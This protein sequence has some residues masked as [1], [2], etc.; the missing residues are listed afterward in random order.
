VNWKDS[1]TSPEGAGEVE[2]N[3]TSA[4]SSSADTLVMSKRCFGTKASSSFDSTMTGADWS[5]EITG[6]GKA[7]IYSHVLFSNKNGSSATWTFARVTVKSELAVEGKEHTVSQYMVLKSFTETITRPVASAVDGITL[8]VSTETKVR[9][10]AKAKTSE[11]YKVYA[12]GGELVQR[13]STVLIPGSM[14][15][16]G[17]EDAE[18]DHPLMGQESVEIV[19]AN[20]I[21]SQVQ[22]E[23]IIGN[24]LITS[25]MSLGL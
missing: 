15:G 22:A 3:I 16:E 9:V 6:T 24:P 19:M 20:M 11:G 1:T 4:V 21:R 5:A 23:E 7:G 17:V 2:L 10:E 18:V 12:T 13:K 14:L 25:Y 8:E